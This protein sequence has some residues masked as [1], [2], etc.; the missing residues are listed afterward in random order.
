[1]LTSAPFVTLLACAL[2]LTLAAQVPQ[3]AAQPAHD[4]A[5][6]RLQYATF[7]PLVQEPEVPPALRGTDDQALWIVQF[8]G[9]PTQKGR[10]AIA[11]A[12][13]QVH[14]YLP[15]DAYVVR[16]PARVADAVRSIDSIRWAGRYHPAYRVDPALGPVPAAATR[17]NLV[18]VDK[19]TDKPALGAKI[20][21]IGGRVDHEQPGSLLYTVT[22]TGPQLLQAA[23]FDEVLWVDLWTPEE[24]DMNNA[25]I[26]GGGNYVEMQGG[27]TGAGINAH[28][29]EGIEATHP[30]FTGG[31]T[32]VLS[33][34]GADD[35]GHCT[36]GIVFG[37]G[38]SHPFARG[39]APDAGKFYTQYS[40]VT[41]G[42]SRWQVVDAL[43]NVYNVS[44]TTASWGNAQVST[45]TSISA[46]TDDII[47][48]HDIAWTQSQSNTGTTL[49]RP[50]AWAKNVFSIGGVQHFDNSNPLDDSYLAGGASHGP[51][52]DGR[53]KPTMCA[54]YDAIAT[55]DRTGAA[56]YSSGNYYNSFNGTSGATPII[57]GHNVLAIQMFTTEVTPGIGLF[58]NPLRNPG[59]TPFSNRPHFTTLKAL[60]VA[61]AA[62]YAFTASSTDN[63]R[64]YQGWGFPD[65]RRM[66][67][68]R[69]KT[70][71][72]DETDVVAQ[73]DASGYDVTVAP[74]EPELRIVLNYSDPAANPAAAVTL[75]NDLS[76][77]VT[78]PGG[79]IY[80]GNSGAWNGNW[81]TPGGTED[82]INPIEVVFLQNPQPGVWKVDIKVTLIAVDS[83]VETP[84]VD[85]DYALV[86]SG[87]TGQPGSPPGF[88]GF[89]TYGQG[90]PGSVLVSQFCTDLN[91][92]GG[93]LTSQTRQWEYCYTV[94]NAGTMTITSFELFTRS[95]G[96]TQTI[97]VHVYPR[98]ATGEPSLTPLVS[99]TITVGPN[100]GFYAVT[101]PAP[102][103]VTGDFF[104]GM[105]SSAQTVVLCDLTTGDAGTGYDR[106]LAVWNLSTL[107]HH[108]SW[109]VTC[110]S[111]PVYATPELGNVG[112][113][114]LNMPY[115]VTLADAAPFSLALCATGLS[116][117]FF[118][119]TPLPL[120][121]PLPGAPGCA[122]L[123]SPD[124]VDLFVTDPLGASI[125]TFV[126]PNNPAFAGI[127]LYHQW[128]V[129]DPVNAIGIVL[130][131]AG[132]ARLGT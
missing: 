21:A 22:L 30:D 26:Q 9:H 6:I 77:R 131:N 85:A 101:L 132:R 5:L 102:L 113:P 65:L 54:Y 106:S 114:F 87:G 124:L 39:M 127:Q 103:T 16:M 74:G 116:N 61:S 95:T 15:D 83:H 10:D 96:G 72:I 76:L 63:R 62:Q 98:T 88:A 36:A 56:G 68:N 48:D 18:V 2:S 4:A 38:T 34:G 125:R 1:M 71:I 12:G 67:D 19:H 14:G 32:N 20:R 24:N 121:F 47:F 82:H 66:Y 119:G 51:A 108:P 118:Q 80:W 122:V 40:S 52:A 43:V 78:S 128:A 37:N 58:G 126:V 11:A 69:N 60:E 109:H 107:I 70:Y 130:S 105:D 45:Y 112:L 64:E 3:G 104:L 55:S 7:D 57:A 129:L 123:V 17:Y 89:T 50:Q 41:A 86:V 90:C 46:D 42:Y 13:G 25:R 92:A 111:G 84:A 100:P 73:G 93:V 79:T 28:I 8:D 27:F 81:T 99:S 53:I 33:A 23:G 75:I 120:P 94:P 91:P 59:G 115:D 35:H 49:S 44:H 117:M 29:Y 110:T 31:A 97:P